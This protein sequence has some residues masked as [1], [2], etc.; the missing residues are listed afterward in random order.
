MDQEHKP[1]DRGKEGHGL[2]LMESFYSI[3]G[4]GYH[5]GKAAWFIR[6][7]GCDVGCVWC[8]VKQSWNADA[9]PEVAITEIMKPVKDLPV[10]MVVVT[11]G[12]P[13]LYDLVVLTKAIHQAGKAAHLETSGAH[14]LSGEW[15]WICLSPKKFRPPVSS[16]YERAD[17][18]KIVVYNKTDLRWAK[19]LVSLIRPKCRLYLQPEWSRRAEMT[20]LIV[21]FVKENPEWEI[22]LQIHKYMNVR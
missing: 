12:E 13:L 20:P 9:W 5:Q 7:A 18:L 22:S 17:E 3:Q 19:E 6:V 11:G 1:A 16:V 8:D 2:P 4:E 10:K 21:E 14:A 15:D